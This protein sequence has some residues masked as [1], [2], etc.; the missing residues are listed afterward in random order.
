MVVRLFQRPYDFQRQ[1]L[2]ARNIGGNAE[3]LRELLRAVLDSGGLGG[4]NISDF[5]PDSRWESPGAILEELWTMGAPIWPDYNLPNINSYLFRPL[6]EIETVID[7]IVTWVD[8]AASQH[9][10]VLFPLDALRHASN[11]MLTQDMS[12]SLNMNEDRSWA[13]LRDI[14]HLGYAENT[15]L[16]RKRKSITE[17]GQNLLASY[18]GGLT[19]VS[20]TVD[21]EGHRELRWMWCLL[22]EITGYD[23][24]GSYPLLR[25]PPPYTVSL[26]NVVEKFNTNT[27]FS[28]RI[29]GRSESSEQLIYILQRLGIDFLLEGHRLTLRERLFL[30][31]NVSDYLRAGLP[32][33]DRGVLQPRITSRQRCVISSP[34]QE[35]RNARIV[36]VHDAAINASAPE[37]AVQVNPL[38]FDQINFD[39]A[40]IIIFREPRPGLLSRYS[41]HLHAFVQ[42]G[43]RLILHRMRQGRRGRTFNILNGLPPDFERLGVVDAGWRFDTT[44]LPDTPIE[45]IYT[46]EFRPQPNGNAAL[47][48]FGARYGRG[49]FIFVHDEPSREFYSELF[50]EYPVEEGYHLD[51]EG[52]HWDN[53]NFAELPYQIRPESAIYPHIGQ[54]VEGGGFLHQRL[55]FEFSTTFCDEWLTGAKGGA[56]L[57]SVLPNVLVI[58]VDSVS[59]EVAAPDTS[60]QHRCSGYRET[61]RDVLTRLGSIIASAPGN[62]VATFRNNI[63]T[64]ISQQPRSYR[65]MMLEVFERHLDA[66]ISE[67][68]PIGSFEQRV[69]NL[70]AN[71]PGPP[72]M[73][74]GQAYGM[75]EDGR[76]TSAREHSE[77][78]G[79]SLWTYRDLYEFIVRTDGMAAQVRREHLLAL[80]MVA[81]PVYFALR[82]R[83]PVDG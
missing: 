73:L 65:S 81:G 83:L 56:D 38:R 61:A 11:G 52:P 34:I 22:R 68:L 1:P 25:D 53:R 31:T 26:D 30:K 23:L 70:G 2:R 59:T 10:F 24:P 58:E 41:G 6:T 64:Q 67:G 76:R 44:L 40:E 82:D 37:H 43:G 66:H 36:V 29:G 15:T 63:A 69:R 28:T 54:S 48:R 14:E 21:L 17:V 51:T 42:S 45:P 20:A 32:G 60:H 57:V 33:V 49:W 80:C 9:P 79:Y 55:G 19:F 18:T 50:E 12:S 16:A 27:A 3:R 77:L 35:I 74:L 78:R 72:T 7:K 8:E 39:Q 13:L 4:S 5:T 71:E 47:T 62:D 75:V 46:Q